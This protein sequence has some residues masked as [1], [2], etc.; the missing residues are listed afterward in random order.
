M[1]RWAAKKDATHQTIQTALERLGWVC[2]DVSRA[3][4]AID[5]V[6]AKAGRVVLVEV[7]SKT[8]R[9]SLGQV[10]I[11]K[12]WPAET[13]ILRDLSDVERLNNG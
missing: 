3:P 4:L 2:L 1:P 10:E 5:L 12:Y 13:A 7:K 11:L 8:G 6:I 9:L